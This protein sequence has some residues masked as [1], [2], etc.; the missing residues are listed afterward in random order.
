MGV[1]VDAVS[2]V[3]IEGVKVG[4]RVWLEISDGGRVVGVVEVQAEEGG[5]SQGV[6]EESIAALAP[7]SSLV[8]EELDDSALPFCSVVVPTI[9]GTP[10]RLQRTVECLVNLDYPHFE[11]IVVDNR[12]DPNRQPLPTFVGGDRV[13]T[14]W[15]PLRGVSAARNFGIAQTTG[16]FIAFTDDD[17]L[18]HPD[19]LLELKTAFDR[20]DCAAVAG[21]VVPLWDQPKP[22]WLEM[23][24]Q[25]AIVNFEFGDEVEEVAFPL[26]ANSAYRRN[27]FERYGVFRLDLGVRGTKHSVTGEDTELGMRLAKAGE[28][29]IYYPSAIVYHPVDPKRA[30]KK[31]FLRWYYYDGVSMTRTVGIPRFG[32]RYFGVPRWLY[33]ELLQSFGKWMFSFDANTRFRHKLKTCRSMGTIVESYRL[34]RQDAVSDSNSTP[35]PLVRG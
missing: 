30:T 15:E 1:D 28:K 2:R 6:L 16:E 22:D 7:V 32:I 31:Y 35:A 3:A 9:C 20:Y 27:V 18:L 14:F 21:R 11:I 33:R 5:V 25:Q 19:W 13:R 8:Y 10:A 17:V 24:G 12:P 29:I 23:D 26:G 4:Q 34:S